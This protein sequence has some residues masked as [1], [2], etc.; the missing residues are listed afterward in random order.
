M[1]PREDAPWQQCP[2]PQCPLRGYGVPALP[3][4]GIRIEV[5]AAT[6][7]AL[8]K[9]RDRALK[10]RD[11]SLLTKVCIVRAMVFPVVMYTC[12]SWTIKKAEH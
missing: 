4:S 5:P 11:I 7:P 9:G 1:W 12:E 2:R 3:P 8:R 10:N 6:E